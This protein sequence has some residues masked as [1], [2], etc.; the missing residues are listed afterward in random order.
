M[1]MLEYVAM[2]EF[3]K[4]RD[5]NIKKMVNWK[6]LLKM[7]EKNKELIRSI[8]RVLS[9]KEL[10]KLRTFIEKTIDLKEVNF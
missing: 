8:I 6:E 3:L 9:T 2:L 7:L 4:K 10:I 5:V 1:V